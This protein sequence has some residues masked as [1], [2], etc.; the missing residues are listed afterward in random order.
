[1]AHARSPRIRISNSHDNHKYARAISRRD[2]PESCITFRSEMRAQGMPGARCA[3][4]LACSKKTRELVTTVT[5]ESPGIPRAMVLTVSFALSPVI[6]LCCH[7]HPADTS[8]RL[9]AGVEASGPHDFAVR[10]QAPSSE[11]PP[12]STASRPASVTIAKRPSVGR[13]GGEYG[14][15]LG[16]RRSGKFFQMGLD[17]ANQI[18][19][20]QQIRFCAHALR[21]GF[22]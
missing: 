21:T 16:R 20:L 15:D 10:K 5:P 9:D 13:D 19:L 7:R 11:A 17:W 22:R 14:S 18:D 12:A 2:A 8:A 3:R 6:G 4:S 1:M